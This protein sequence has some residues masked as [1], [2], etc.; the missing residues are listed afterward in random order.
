MNEHIPVSFTALNDIRDQAYLLSLGGASLCED[1]F[2]V[3]IG[4]FIDSRL[5]EVKE[6]I[7]SLKKQFPGKFVSEVNTDDIVESLGDLSRRLQEPDKG[8]HE[9]CAAGE[10]GKELERTVRSL[11]RAIKTIKTQVEGGAP[12]Y[13]KTD[14]ALNL[15]RRIGS[16]R[17][18]VPLVAKCLVPLVIAAVFVFFFLFI[19]MEKESTFLEKIVQDEEIVQSQQKK[20]SEWVLEKK[21]ASSKIEDLRRNGMSR[22]DKITVL[23]LSIKVQDLEKK[24]GNLQEE[25]YVHETRIRNNRKKIEDMKAKSFVKRLLRR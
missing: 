4:T 12:S 22:Q 1:P 11:T 7:V 13:S 14:S 10:L 18:L 15:F 24:T 21:T 8:I 23:E 5:D 16:I 3:K 20:L 19:T 2:L 25:I 9:K 6:N 17:S